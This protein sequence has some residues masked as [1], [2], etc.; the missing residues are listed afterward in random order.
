MVDLFDLLPPLRRVG[1]LLRLEATLRAAFAADSTEEDLC[2]IPRGASAQLLASLPSELW[3]VLFA[4]AIPFRCGPGAIASSRI[5][6]RARQLI[7]TCSS[8]FWVRTP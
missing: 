3:R 6:V 8:V 5:R 4:R 2:Y 7:W 1:V